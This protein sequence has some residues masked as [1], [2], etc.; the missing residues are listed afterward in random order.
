MLPSSNSSNV[1][2]LTNGK[3]KKCSIGNSSHFGT[4]LK[5]NNV[6]SMTVS[7]DGDYIYLS[8]SKALLGYKLTK[9]SNN[10][11]C[12]TDGNWEYFINTNNSR[13]EQRGG[14]KNTYTDDIK[15]IY[16]IEY[17]KTENNKIYTTS[18]N[19]HL[20]QRI[21]V[22][23]TNFTASLDLSIGKNGAGDVFNN[24]DPGAVAASDVEFNNPGRAA[25]TSVSNN[26]FASSSRV[27]VGDRNSFIHKFDENKLTAALKDTAWRARFGGGK[28]TKF[29]GAKDAIEAI[30]TDSSL[31][32]GANF[33][34]IRV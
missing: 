26:L 17:S 9:D 14:V 29:Q 8:A 22:D 12:P 11:Y 30:V 1:K 28:V 19:S 20:L 23:H 5:N 31:T 7:N 27:L 25:S 21:E 33:G 6:W 24:K 34:L 2:N 4:K 15:D 18:F 10:L 3:Q 13:V 16:S 32:S